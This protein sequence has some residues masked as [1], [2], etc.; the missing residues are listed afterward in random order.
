MTLGQEDVGN[1]LPLLPGRINSGRVVCAG[2]EQ[3][4][5]LSRNRLEELGVGGEAKSDDLRVVVRVVF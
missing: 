2:V 3:D 4:D 1:F 5:R